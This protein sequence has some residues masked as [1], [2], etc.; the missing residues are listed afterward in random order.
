M[1]PLL[2]NDLPCRWQ[3]IEA[4]AGNS[5]DQRHRF[6]IPDHSVLFY[7]PEPVPWASRSFR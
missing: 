7:E 1:A 4:V 6:R 2:I 5:A 3:G